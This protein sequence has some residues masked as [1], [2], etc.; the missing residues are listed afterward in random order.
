MKN[1]EWSNFFL[2]IK[3][4]KNYLLAYLIFSNTLVVI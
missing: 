1:A 3:I 2:F 4:Y